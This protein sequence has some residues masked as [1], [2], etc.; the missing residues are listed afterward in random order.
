MSESP[1][2]RGVVTESLSAGVLHLIQ[3]SDVGKI[4]CNSDTI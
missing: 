3:A 1:L 2:F 4:G